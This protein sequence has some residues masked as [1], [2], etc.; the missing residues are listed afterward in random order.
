MDNATTAFCGNKSLQTKRIL[1]KLIQHRVIIRVSTNVASELHFVCVG[2]N[3]C[4][5]LGGRV[6]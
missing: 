6:V 5:L 2:G 3:K 1:L 4:R